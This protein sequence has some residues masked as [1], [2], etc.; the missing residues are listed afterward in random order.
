MCWGGGGWGGA[1]C[2]LEGGEGGGKGIWLMFGSHF[3]FWFGFDVWIPRCVL[4]LIRCLDPSLCFVLD[5]M[6]GF[7][8]DVWVFLCVFEF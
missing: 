1:G 3:V 4:I 6:W 2:I 8:F 7:G 5:L